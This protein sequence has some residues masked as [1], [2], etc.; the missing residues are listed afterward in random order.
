MADHALVQTTLQ[1]LHVDDLGELLNTPIPDQQN[2]TQQ[3]QTPNIFAKENTDF[4]FLD[5]KEGPKI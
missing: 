4:S 1:Q 3:N 2:S 5:K